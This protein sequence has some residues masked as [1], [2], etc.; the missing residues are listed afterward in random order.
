LIK[1]E[2][3]REIEVVRGNCN[4]GNGLQHL[5]I[6]QNTLSIIYSTYK[7]IKVEGGKL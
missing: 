7:M 1:R 6:I 3:E 5:K 4:E 2:R